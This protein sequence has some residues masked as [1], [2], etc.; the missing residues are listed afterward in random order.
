MGRSI[1]AIAAGIGAVVILSILLDSLMRLVG[2]F[3]PASKPMLGGGLFAIATFYRMVVGIAGSWLAARLAP[4]RPLRHALIVGGIGLM[5]AL[6]GALTVKDQGSGWYPWAL[7]I[8]AMPAAWL[9]GRLAMRGMQL[10]TNDK[11]VVL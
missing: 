8:I 6:A 5:L 9:G 4:S 7:V 11:G 1:V 3:P 10:P 2:I